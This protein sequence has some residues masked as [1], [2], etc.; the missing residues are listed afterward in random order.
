MFLPAVNWN[1]NTTKYHHEHHRYL[2]VYSLTIQCSCPLWTE[3]EIQPNTT[4]N[5]TGTWIYEYSK[6]G[7]KR[8]LKKDQKFVFKTDYRLMQVKSTVKPV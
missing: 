5:T 2:N 7:L 6:T 8:S 4:M 3:T 1:W